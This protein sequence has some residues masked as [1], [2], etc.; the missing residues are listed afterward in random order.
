MR[1]EKAKKKIEHRKS[2]KGEKW[3]LEGGGGKTKTGLRAHKTP[4][5]KKTKKGPFVAPGEEKKA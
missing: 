2:G 5:G 3:V 4:G 1:E